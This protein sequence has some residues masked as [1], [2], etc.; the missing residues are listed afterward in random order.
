VP[1]RSA[2]LVAAWIAEHQNRAVTSARE[3][4]RELAQE[5]GFDLVGFAPLRRPQRAERLLEWL[6]AGRHAGMDWLARQTH[7]TLAPQRLLPG[8]RS[9]VMLGLG[10]SRARVELADGARVAR[11]AAGR[12][13]HNVAGRQLIRLGKRLAR[14][15]LVR[16]W[17]KFADAGP[18]LERSHAAEAGLGCE[19]KAANL[20]H[21]RFGPWFFL[22]ELLVDSAWEPDGGPGAIGC[23]TCTACI[24]ACPT[25]AIGPDGV[26]DARACISF[27]TIESRASVPRELRGGLGAW[28]FGCDVC[29]EVCPWGARAPDLAARFGTHAAVA[30]ARVADW[31][32][33]SDAEFDARFEGSPLRRAGAAGLARNAAH[34]LGALPAD[35]RHRDALARALDAHPSGLVRVAA[36]WSLARRYRADAGVDA[37][38][39]RALARETDPAA[40]TDMRENLS[41]PGVAS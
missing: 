8:G 11:Y 27:H 7:D 3:Q 19:S 5:S 22:A 10:H 38:L 32:T 14:A 16:R 24:D 30:E 9:L 18:L 39:A 23:G 25:H 34:A 29:S 2:S 1:R 35:E 33:L 13:Y 26:V 40:R 31:L 20:L 15:G 28:V 37:A 17:R 6:A 4:V 12:D 21:P 41:Q 36:A